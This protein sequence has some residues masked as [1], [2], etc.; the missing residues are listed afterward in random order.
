MHLITYLVQFS[1]VQLLSCVWLFRTL[2]T[3]ACWASLSITNCWSLLKDISI[4]SVMPSSRL[5]L[6]HPVSSCLQS[7]PESGSFLMSQLFTSCGQSI[8]ASASA[9]VLPVNIRGWF[10]LGLT[11][12]ISL[13]PKGLSRV[14]AN[15]T[16]WKHQFFSAQ[17]FISTVF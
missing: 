5:V 6:C 2:W 14:F 11:G 12:L 15:T 8:E 1:S 3:T 9:S 17:P 10:P 4:E 16:V 13:M 7:F